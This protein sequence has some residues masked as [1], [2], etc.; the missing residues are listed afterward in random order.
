MTWGLPS[1]CFS[2]CLP[3]HPAPPPHAHLGLQAQTANLKFP[4]DSS[5]SAILL[6]PCSDFYSP[7]PPAF[8][9]C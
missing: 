3:H 5:S 8:W 9:V 4:M 2:S 7:P 6:T 1:A